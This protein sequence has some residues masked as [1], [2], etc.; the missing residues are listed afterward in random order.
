VLRYHFAVVRLWE[1][2]YE[3]VLDQAEPALWP[4]ATLM[5]GATVGTTMV[6]AERL[7]H[8]PLPRAERSELTGLL[9]ALAGLRLPPDIVTQAL[10][11]NPMIR[12][13]LDESSVAALWRE[14]GREAGREEGREEGQRET[15]RLVLESRF[16]S[17]D[18]AVLKKLQEADAPTLRSLVT[19]LATD[20]W[21]QVRERLG[22]DA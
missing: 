2:P 5:K 12:E 7:A 19:H 13:I 6:V 21:E 1:Q 8:A 18:A 20:R 22:L 3:R 11:R 16:G 17:L 14:E 4:L 10:R 15:L 9:A